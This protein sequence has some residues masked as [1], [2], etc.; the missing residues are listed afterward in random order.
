MKTTV[1]VTCKDR[2]KNVEFCMA[3]IAKAEPRPEVILVDFGSVESLVYLEDRYENVRVIRVDHA[4]DMFHKSRAINIGVKAATTEY[5]C[6]TD[7]D[8][9]FAKNFFGSVESSISKNHKGFVVCYT[10]ILT[11]L[12]E[13]ATWDNVD[14]IYDKLLELAKK[15]TVKAYG[16]GCCNGLRRAAF[17]KMHG[18][19]EGYIGYRSEDS[20]F[21]L[22][23][24]TRGM[25]VINIY[26][27]TSMVHL[28]HPKNGAYYAHHFQNVNYNRYVRSK[29]NGNVVANIGKKWGEL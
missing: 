3:S 13:Y 20:D 29:K 21:W 2:K 25:S 7:A 22:R 6:I 1:I 5:I 17:M 23:A 8:Q 26:D 12:P 9:I 15:G 14:V 10:E 24:E 11:K 16:D 18:Y 19:D 27:Q 4:T 28:P